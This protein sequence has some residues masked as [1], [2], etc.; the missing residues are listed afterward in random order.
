M[1]HLGMSGSMRIT[2]VTDQPEKHDH[3]DI[4]NDIGE[5]VRFHDPRRFGSFL[6]A[7]KT[8]DNHPLLAALGPEPLGPDFTGKYLWQ[9]G[10]GKRV[11]IKQHIMNS[12]VV[13]G[14]GNI[15]ANEA[16]F[17]AG[18]HPLRAAG[19]ISS[20][21]MDALADAISDVLRDA[22]QQGGTTLRD[23]RGGDGKPGYFKQ[24]LLVYERGNDACKQCGTA[25]KRS[26]IG[27]RATYY[28]PI[29]QR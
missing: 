19:R 3:F 28:C 17:R 29:C 1:I 26:V 6:W 27:Q 13:A 9:S 23:Y 2:K 20:A 21:R 15:Y 16:L 18:I 25:I 12:K 5:I 8:P 24:Q 10:R 11:A 22:I 14:V 7:G 4:V